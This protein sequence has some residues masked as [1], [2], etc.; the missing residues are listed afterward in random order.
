MSYAHI[1][2][3]ALDLHAVFDDKE[4][5]SWQGATYFDG[6]Y[7]EIPKRPHNFRTKDLQ[8]TIDECNE[9]LGI[10][11]ENREKHGKDFGQWVRDMLASIDSS[12]EKYKVKQRL[13]EARFNMVQY[14]KWRKQVTSIK[15]K[16][17]V[18]KTA[19]ETANDYRDYPAIYFPANLDWRSRVYPMCAGLT[20][21]GVCLQKALIKFSTGKPI[22]SQDALDW[23]FIHTANTHGEDKASWN[24]RLE[25]TK[26][27]RE[28]IERV[29]EDPLDNVEDW[30][31]TD[32]PWLFLAAC[33][34][35]AKYYEHGL[36]A[37]V[38]IP[39]PMDG[40]CNGAQHYAAMT[41]DLDGAYQVN[42]A[43]NGT[44]D[45]KARLTELRA[46]LGITNPTG[47]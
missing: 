7:Q 33:E 34:Q 46:K 31:H 6:W 28:L 8:A 45:L 12:S 23:L 42:V 20:T 9:I 39:I 10:T 32:D 27:N 36:D 1:D 22:G 5:A 26:N 11:I 47:V 41:R 17:R 21:Q 30:I 15:S 3:S 4:A 43:P 13:E 29:A 16:N 25:W 24:D 2:I 37:V 19:L 18:I 40:T 35:M 38:D 44:Q 14:S